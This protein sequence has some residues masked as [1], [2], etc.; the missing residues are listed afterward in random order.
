[1][2]DATSGLHHVTAI[3]GDPA[4]NVRFYTD[5]LGLRLVKRTVNFDDPSTYHL[6]YGDEVG[7]P[8]TILTFFP[9]V[10]GRSGRVGR[11]QTSATAFAVPEGSL[12]Y[13]RERLAER[14]VDVDDPVDRFGER[15]LPFRDG[16]GQ[17]LELVAGRTGGTIEPWADGP[18]PTEHAVRGFHGV[19]L[20]SLDPAA[21]A[22]VLETLGYEPV[23]EAGD[24]S[25]YRA[26][27]GP[28]GSDGGV[29]AVVDVLDRPDAPRGEEGI[30]TVHHVAVRA[31]DADQQERW[32]ERLR[33]A[34]HR[35]TPRKDRRYF[36]SVYLREP[37]GIL[38]E[39]ATDGP[40]FDRDESVPELGSSL[41]LP[42]WLEDDRERIENRLP[43]IGSADATEGEPT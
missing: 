3:A 23:A 6:Y 27:A 33:E 12:A 19:T 22:G 25:R 7:S 16:D 21:T 35:V 14:G 2:N 1:M 15:V 36:E 4:E 24:R 43:T 5:V 32:R 20:D 29:A 40:G 34:G 39:I 28:V 31:A 17:P 13:W 10:D 30:G 11:G 9:F 41:K 38:F 8:G 42:P 18:V 26:T 37:G